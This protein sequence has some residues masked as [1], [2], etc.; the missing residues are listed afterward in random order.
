MLCMCQDIYTNTREHI[1]IELPASKMTEVAYGTST[2]Y[3][4]AEILTIK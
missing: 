3:I 2:E 4:K 1:F